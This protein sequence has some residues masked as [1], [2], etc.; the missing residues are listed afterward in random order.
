MARQN[1]WEF[2]NCG[3]EP[4]GLKVGELG[5][6]PASNSG[7]YDGLNGGK[8]AGR[9]CWMAAGTFCSEKVQA[10]SAEKLYSCQECDFFKKVDKEEGET[11][12]MLKAADWCFPSAV[13]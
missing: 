13:G 11:F 6:C 10:T 8:Y 9:L 12:V 5:I 3:R 7:I 4:E 2:K 1:C